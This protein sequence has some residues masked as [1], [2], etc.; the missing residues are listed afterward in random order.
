MLRISN[1]AQLNNT[2]F[3]SRALLT[4]QEHVMAISNYAQVRH[5]GNH[6]HHVKL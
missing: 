4:H 1:Q 2:K 3:Q 5:S 6:L